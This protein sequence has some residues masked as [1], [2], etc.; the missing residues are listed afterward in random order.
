MVPPNPPLATRIAPYGKAA[1]EEAC[2]LILVGE[3][4]AV[5]TETVYGLAADA[6]NAD[7]VARIYAARGRPGFTPLIVHVRV[8]GRGEEIAPFPA[9]ARA[10][11]LGWWRG[12]L[13]LVLPLKEEGGIAPA[14]TAGLATI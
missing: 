7:A 12:P 11:A 1:V 6:T 4:V 14:V 13:P 3:P 9:A 10:L 8:L 5:P 2:R